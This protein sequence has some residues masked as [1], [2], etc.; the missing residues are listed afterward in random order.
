[1][2]AF[3]LQI[4]AINYVICGSRNDRGG[5]IAMIGRAALIFE[6][7]SWHLKLACLH[8]TYTLARPFE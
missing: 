6:E 8:P 3:D 1:M 4:V 5:A 7:A 2:R